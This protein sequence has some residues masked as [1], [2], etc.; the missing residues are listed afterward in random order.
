MQIGTPEKGSFNENPLALLSDCHRRVEHFLR[1]LIAVAERANGR[2]LDME[3]RDAQER[4]L[5][6]FREAAPKHTQDEEQS[7]FPRMRDL[8]NPEVDAAMQRIEALEAD[9]VT[10]NAQHE[11]VDH[12]GAKWLQ[13]PLAEDEFRRYRNALELL[14]QLYRRHIEVEDNDIFPLASRTLP[15]Q[16]QR[17]IGLEMAARRMV[18]QFEP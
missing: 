7:L 13:G 5:R 17:E 1:A 15:P 18:K 2:A 12:L 11:I 8:H 10:A 9:H 6:Y 14:D 16:T 3:E 4:S